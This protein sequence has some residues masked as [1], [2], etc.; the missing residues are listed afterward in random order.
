ML[1][2]FLTMTWE[3]DISYNTQDWNVKMDVF[4]FRIIIINSLKQRKLSLFTSL[5]TETL[6]VLYLRHPSL[7]CIP[8]PIFLYTHNI[9]SHSVKYAHKVSKEIH[10][11]NNFTN[12]LSTTYIRN[13]SI[14]CHIK[15]RKTSF[16]LLQ[17]LWHLWKGQWIANYSFFWRIKAFSKR[18]VSAQGINKSRIPHRKE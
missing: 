8:K 10:Y 14:S 2:V 12:F 17:S 9:K 18:Q 4:Q 5:G 1:P 7:M 11:R 15:A 16:H 6:R 3:I 13:L